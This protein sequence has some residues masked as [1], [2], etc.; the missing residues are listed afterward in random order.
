MSEWQ[1]CLGPNGRCYTCGEQDPSTPECEPLRRWKCEC[2]AMER[3]AQFYV[4]PAAP[5]TESKK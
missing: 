5:Q 1:H 3:R 4:L 2:M